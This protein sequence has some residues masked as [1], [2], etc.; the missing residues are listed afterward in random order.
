MAEPKNL[1]TSEVT[2]D[3]I[4]RKC[5]YKGDV[6]SYHPCIGYN[7]IRCPECGSTHNEHNSIYLSRMLSAARPPDSPV[8]FDS[9]GG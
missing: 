1:G 8:D 6:H 3:V 4:C 5:G 7:D 9:H 2:G